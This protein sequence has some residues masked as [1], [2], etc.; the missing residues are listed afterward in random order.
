[1][2]YFRRHSVLSFETTGDILLII[3]APVNRHK[4]TINIKN[5]NKRGL[6]CPLFGIT[7]FTAADQ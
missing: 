4:I 1:M 7:D 2:K 5:S 3:L 6:T